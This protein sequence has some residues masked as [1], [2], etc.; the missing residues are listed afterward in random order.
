[1]RRTQRFPHAILTMLIHE[2][3]HE[4]PRF[5]MVLSVALKISR[6]CV[7][8]VYVCLYNFSCRRIYQIDLIGVYFTCC[9]DFSVKWGLDLANAHLCG[10][11]A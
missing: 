4:I 11:R 1:M 8:A 7:W 10:R 9:L 6:N 5:F 3:M 2:L